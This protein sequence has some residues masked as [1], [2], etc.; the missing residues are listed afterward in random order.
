MTASPLRLLSN[1]DGLAAT[2][3]ALILPVLLLMFFGMLEG[4]DILTVSRRLSHTANT[5]A[6]LAARER[7]I[8]HT[9]LNDMLVGARRLLEPTN[10]STLNITVVSV[11]SAGSP[12]RPTVHWSRDINGATPYAAGVPYMNLSNTASLNAASSLIVVEIDYTY[13]SGLTSEVFHRPYTFDFEA[14]RLPRKSTRVQLCNTA[15]P[16]VCT[17]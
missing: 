1:R 14:K 12:A 6:D 15:T 9:E 8:N 16:V 7:T 10:T 17:S 5:V 2:E 3:F 4:S 13:D 11:I